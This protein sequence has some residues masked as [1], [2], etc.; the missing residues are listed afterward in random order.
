M[1]LQII[2]NLNF[3]FLNIKLSVLFVI[4]ANITCVKVDV[5]RN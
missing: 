1:W 2:H 3:S 5:K 4:Y